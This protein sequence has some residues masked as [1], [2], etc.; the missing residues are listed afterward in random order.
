MVHFSSRG[1]L[2]IWSDHH[3]EHTLSVIKICK[4]AQLIKRL[5]VTIKKIS[6]HAH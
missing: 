4:T 2:P 3:W 1:Q 5:N 6:F